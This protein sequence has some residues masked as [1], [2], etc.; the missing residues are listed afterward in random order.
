MVGFN[1]HEVERRVHDDVR[2]MSSAPIGTATKD[3]LTRTGVTTPTGI[4]VGARAC[5]EAVVKSDPADRSPLHA[6]LSELTTILSW[7]SN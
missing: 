4:E 7:R 5:L 3:V 6:V 1:P 2:A